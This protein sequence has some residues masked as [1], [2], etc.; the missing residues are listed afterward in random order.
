MWKIVS[1]LM[2]TSIIMFA[3]QADETAEPKEEESSPY[4]PLGYAQDGAIE[5]R[6]QIPT[7]KD[8]YFKRTA[9]EEF[10]NAKYGETNRSHD[11]DFN[12][13]DAMAVVE[14]VN[15]LK[16]ITMTQA[17]STDDKVYVAVMINPYDM[18]D[19]TIPGKI[20]A[21]VK[22][23]TDKDL[24]VYTNNS[25]WDQMKNFNSRQDT[26]EAPKKIRERMRNFFNQ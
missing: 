16:E 15:E 21:K 12:N 22:Q 6:G 8:S 11:N 13:E 1:I 4:Q 10:R 7:G 2:L 25:S 18:R 9:E 20:E 19:E 23:V 5:R 24:I 17:Y 14:K 26:S 3:C